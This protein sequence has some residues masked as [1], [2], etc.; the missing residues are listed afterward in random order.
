M[1]V[2]L[3]PVLAL[4]A[5]SALVLV[6]A[7]SAITG[8]QYDGN[9]HP[10]VGFADNGVF[11]CSGTLLSPTVMLTAAH[12]FSTSTSIFGTDT[13]SGAPIVRVS[14]DPNLVNTPQAQ[15]VWSFGSYYFD[16]E[17]RLRGG[18][19]LPG[20]DTHDL[21]LIV[22]AA[23][24]CAVPPGQSGSCG[25]MAPS[26]TSGQYG[27]LPTQGFDS[28]LAMNTPVEIAGFGVQDFIRGGGP[29]GGPCKPGP[30]SAF[31]RFSAQTSL[32][33]SR[34]RLGDTFIKLHANNGGVCFGDS[35]GPDVLAGTHTIL[36]VNSF[37]TNDL[38]NG[39]TYSYRLDT[40]A[41]LTWITSEATA[42]GGTL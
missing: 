5:T 10:Y 17:F 30:G 16:P 11:A 28:A 14:F 40:A 19:G 24:G 31:T 7:G 18:G 39:V 25:P 27:Q 37:D 3:L 4:T 26:V 13:V 2:R 1:P 42:A 8:G 33:T 41:A 35:G 32:V 21:A 20:L 15:R 23:Q 29:C 34:D 12:C 6:A 9:N 22:F 36:A 38:C